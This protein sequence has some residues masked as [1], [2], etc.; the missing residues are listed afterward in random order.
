MVASDFQLPTSNLRL[1]SGASSAY[2][3]SSTLPQSAHA[4]ISLS[5]STVHTF[6][7]LHRAHSVVASKQSFSPSGFSNSASIRP[8]YRVTGQN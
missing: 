4:K 2:S 3:I 7:L 6:R 5:P 8:P 1:Q